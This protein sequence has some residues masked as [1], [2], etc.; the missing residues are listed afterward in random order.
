[1]RRSNRNGKQS[2]TGFAT[3]SPILSISC[4][5]VFLIPCVALLIA[6]PPAGVGAIAVPLYI[7]GVAWWTL[8]QPETKDR[9]LVHK[10]ERHPAK[11]EELLTRALHQR[12]QDPTL[13]ACVGDLR[14]N[15][16][17]WTEARDMYAR[18]LILRPHDVRVR[19]ELG[20]AHVQLGEWNEAVEVLE[21]ARQN[22]V[23]TE[24]SRASI[25]AHLALA[26]VGLGDLS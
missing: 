9:R 18:V 22:P 25:V 12:P 17:K 11:A 5:V 26:Y 7:I 6:F 21:V 14:R 19:V 16:K 15:Q 20:G 10:I 8:A 4:G 13:I 3:Q 2:L 23:L 1:M 24:E